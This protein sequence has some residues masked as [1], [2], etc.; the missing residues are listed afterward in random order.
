MDDPKVSLYEQLGGRA[1][2]ERV[3]KI[4]YD[5]LYAHPWIGQFFVD[6]PRNVIEPQQTDFMAQ[7]FG[8]PAMYCGKFPIPAHK[9]MFI[10][11]E[12]F[13]LRHTMLGESLQA[14]G[15]APPLA[16]SWLDVDAAF[17]ARLVKRSPSE[18]EGRFKME[19]IMVVPKVA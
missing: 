1:T 8:G 12:L 19:P 4:F 6:V 18:C 11:E 2:L 15:V 16:A 14:A 10:T 13:D 5:K 17:K 7:T 9:H 3:H